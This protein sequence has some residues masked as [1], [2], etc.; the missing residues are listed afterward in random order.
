[1]YQSEPQVRRRRHCRERHKQLAS[2]V[3][4]G[5]FNEAENRVR[6]LRTYS[7]C[8]QQDCGN[9]RLFGDESRE[10][11]LQAVNTRTILCHLCAAMDIHRMHLRVAKELE[12]MP[13]MLPQSVQP[14]NVR[15]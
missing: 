14:C 8:N 1:L 10:S 11:A 3:D 15:G 5:F 6:W 13:V 7:P 2:A 12:L 4:A 9:Q